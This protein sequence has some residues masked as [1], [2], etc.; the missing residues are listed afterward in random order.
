MHDFQRHFSR[1]FQVLE[2]SRKKIQDFPGGT[3]ELTLTGFSKLQQIIRSY[4]RSHTSNENSAAT[5]RTQLTQYG[6]CMYRVA[7]RKVEH[8]CLT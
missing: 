8:T 5:W 4:Q 6:Y 2:F 7:Y 3:G 1:T